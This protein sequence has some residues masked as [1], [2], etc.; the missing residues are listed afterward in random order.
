ML[1]ELEC[2]VRSEASV[3][4]ARLL[5]DRRKRGKVLMKMSFSYPMSEKD[6]ALKNLAK[7]GAI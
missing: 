6:K 4:K 7:Y 2:C 1:C 3:H 5:I